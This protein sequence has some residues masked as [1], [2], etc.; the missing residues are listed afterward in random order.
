M[1]KGKDSAQVASLDQFIETLKRRKILWEMHL[2]TAAPANTLLSGVV[3]VTIDGDDTTVNANSMIGPVNSGSRLFVMFVPPSGYYIVGTLGQSSAAADV[4]IFTSNGTWNKPAF[5]RL[6]N[7]KV[8]GGGGGGGG[9]ATAAA[10]QSS[11]GG[12]GGAG[13]YSESWVDATTL[14]DQVTVTLGT[15]GSG[16]SNSGGGGGS[17]TASSFGTVVIANGGGGGSSHASSATP[18]ASAA[19]GGGTTGTGQIAVGGDPGQPGWSDTTIAYGGAGGGAGGGASQYTPAGGGI[20]AGSPG[21]GFGAGGS[22]AMAN[23]G[24]AGQVGGDG[25]GGLVMVITQ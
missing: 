4:Q 15:G 14:D 7:I 23:S 6:V 20:R 9:C 2:A 13:G 3:P 25:A 8:W 18:Q 24:G 21:A 5:A 12:G 11:C 10:G 17:G 19:G 1:T 22:G 16:G